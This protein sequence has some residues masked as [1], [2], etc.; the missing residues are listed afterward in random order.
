MGER[1][2]S[3]PIPEK[4]TVDLDCMGCG[5]NMKTLPLASHCPEC[6]RA[7]M[8]TL[9]GWLTAAVKPELVR[10]MIEQV[11]WL[12]WTP[13]V[14]FFVAAIAMMVGGTGPALFTMMLF[15]A[16]HVLCTEA[17]VGTA[18]RMLNAPRSARVGETAL[19]CAVAALVAAICLQRLELIV[20]GLGITTTAMSIWSARSVT[21]IVDRAGPPNLRHWALL[22]HRPCQAGVWAAALLFLHEAIGAWILVRPLETWCG[23]LSKGFFVGV[24]IVLTAWLTLYPIL[25]FRTRGWLVE[26]LVAVAFL[27]SAD[28]VASPIDSSF[29]EV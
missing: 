18:E 11:R 6:G 24:S 29:T 17:F 20:L 12:G 1:T 4:I 15:T 9:G 19:A 7:V 8:E 10:A 27:D 25:M 13:L 26:A 5:Y 23:P 16:V 2:A 21:L 28:H 3:S 22:T 14:G